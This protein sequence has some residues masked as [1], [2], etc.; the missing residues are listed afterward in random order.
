LGIEPFEGQLWKGDKLCALACGLFEGVE[1]AANVLG[2]VMTC[3]LLDQ[4]DLHPGILRPSEPSLS[5]DICSCRV[6]SV[7]KAGSSS[8]HREAFHAIRSS[9]DQSSRSNNP[10]HCGLSDTRAWRSLRR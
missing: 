3:A 10:P 2:F 5:L 1:A 8:A 4:S 6:D 9:C 7:G